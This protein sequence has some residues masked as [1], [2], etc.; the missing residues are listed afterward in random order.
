MK[1]LVALML[2]FCVSCSGL[3]RDTCSNLLRERVWGDFERET[4]EIDSGIQ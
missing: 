4:K 1:I 2:L 3:V